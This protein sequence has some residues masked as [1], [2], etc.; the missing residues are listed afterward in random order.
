MRRIAIWLTIAVGAALVVE[1]LWLGTLNGTFSGDPFTLL[2]V[3]S[4]VTYMITGAILAIRVP[5][6]PIG[7]LFLVIALGLLFGGGTAEYA[8]YTVQ[9]NPGALPGSD[10]AAWINNWTFVIAGLIPIVLI[11]FP[12]GRPPSHRWRW[13]L[14]A[15]GATLAVLVVS[16]MVRP[17]PIELNGDLTVPNPTGIEA[18]RTAAAAAAWIGGLL[19]AAESIAAVGA[20]VV[21]FR[22]ADE[23]ERQ[24]VRWIAV[25]A[26]L[27]GVFLVLV[28]VTS[29]GLGPGESRPVNDLAFLLFFLC[30]SVGI[31][32][33]VAVALLKYHLYDLDVVVKKTVLYVTVAGLLLV[34]FAVAAVLVG[35]IFGRSQRAA[36]I[37]AA[38][39]GVAVWPAIRI[40]RRVADRIVYGGRATPYEVLTSF[41]R[42]MSETYATDDVVDRTAQ[43]LASATGASSAAVWLRVGREFR[44]AGTWPATGPVGRAIAMEGDDLPML[45]AD[46]AEPVRDRGELLGALAVTMPAN[47]P[48]GPGRQ[49]LLRDLADQAGLALRNVRLIEELRA[50]R[51]RLVAAQDE[52]RR[53]LERNIHDGVQQQLVALAVKLRLADGLIDRDTVRAHD[54]IAAL[55][56][57]A[58]AAL[59]DLRDLAR[60]IY[61][62]LLADRGLRAALEAQAQKATTPVRVDGES[63]GRYPR[64]IESTVYFCAL[65][66]M[67]NIAKYAEA[68]AASVRLEQRDGILRFTVRDDGRGFD[69]RAAVGGTGLQGMTDRLEAVGGSLLVESVIGSGTTVTGT[70]PVEPGQAEADSQAA[71]SRSGPNDDL[72]M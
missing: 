22:R 65:E 46:W 16:A 63:V 53:R 29:I 33:A 55:Q 49:R 39:I 20:L 27:A 57:D 28:L 2:I 54:A 67:N 69:P 45:P 9:T 14:W 58:N 32:G 44:P 38:A 68:T 11:L 52:G 19:L 51:Q 25:A 36:V 13:V 4:V 59:E 50:S 41:G 56:N 15:I 66:A 30:L 5:H 8:T 42:R 12:T 1:A 21:R 17:I 31:P 18:L 61:P 34:A 3:L 6:N 71:S 40:A 26:A 23:E 72:G 48:I 70:V 10:W 43:L 62:P 37:A 24:Q 35:G 64:E 7:W 60:G 47:D